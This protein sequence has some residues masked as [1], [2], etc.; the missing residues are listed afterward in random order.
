MQNSESRCDLCFQ[1]YVR[2][3]SN[4]NFKIFNLPANSDELSYNVKSF[5]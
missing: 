2:S 3:T 4:N 1:R 5:P